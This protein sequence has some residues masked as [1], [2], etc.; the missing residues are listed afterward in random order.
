CEHKIVAKRT[1]VSPHT[2]STCFETLVRWDPLPEKD[3]DKAVEGLLSPYRELDRNLK[4]DPWIAV[5]HKDQFAGACAHV[6]YLSYATEAELKQLISTYGQGKHVGGQY[7]SLVERALRRAIDIDCSLP[8]ESLEKI[9]RM[10][11]G[12]SPSDR[13]I[14][15]IIRGHALRCLAKVKHPDYD[16][17]LL[18]AFDSKDRELRFAA[19]EAFSQR[20]IE[21]SLL[22][23]RNALKSNR[24]RFEDTGEIHL[25]AIALH[26]Q[27]GDGRVDE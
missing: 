5:T 22:V 12:T 19:M 17:L 1:D 15:L 20:R 18:E 3:S 26:V 21:G 14:R 27:A 25:A 13:K 23:I 9:Y 4:L 10:Q 11:Q 16:K 2:Q 8:P 24:A 6:Y 7:D